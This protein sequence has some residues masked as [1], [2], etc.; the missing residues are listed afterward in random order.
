MNT[1]RARWVTCFLLYSLSASPALSNKEI[2]LQ[3]LH[4]VRRVS[5]SEFHLMIVSQQKKAT[6]LEEETSSALF[7]EIV[8]KVVKNKLEISHN[9]LI[10]SI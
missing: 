4:R 9:H 8:L 7:S 2:G 10:N 3:A 6:S 1:N 5:A